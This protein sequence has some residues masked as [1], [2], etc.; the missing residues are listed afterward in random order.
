MFISRPS[1]NRQDEF[2][3]VYIHEASILEIPLELRTWAGFH[4]CG[5][6]PFAE[7]RVEFG[8]CATFDALLMMSESV[9][10]LL[11]RRRAVERVLRVRDFQD[12]S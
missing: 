4:S 3:C 5:K 10:P 12:M 9:L 7:V 2:L 6:C 1:S 11:G 8:R